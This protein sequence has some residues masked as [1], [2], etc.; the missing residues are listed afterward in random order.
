MSSP[1]DNF[2]HSGGKDGCSEHHAQS[3]R[4]VRESTENPSKVQQRNVART[5]FTI[6]PEEI[7]F[8]PIS[9][10]VFHRRV[11][12]MLKMYR[13]SATVALVAFRLSQLLLNEGHFYS[14]EMVF[15]TAIYASKRQ[16]DSWIP[17]VHGC[18]G[19]CYRTTIDMEWRC[20]HLEITG[21]LE[22]FYTY[23]EHYYRELGLVHYDQWADQILSRCI[24][25][26]KMVQPPASEIESMVRQYHQIVNLNK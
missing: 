10:G 13:C 20:F 7:G 1:S 11:M 19:I 25:R 12:E 16:S 23:G 5:L 3:N 24:A 22:H 2:G 26:W 18:I 14:K 6:M 21:N 4:E 17:L 15:A 9:E 8:H